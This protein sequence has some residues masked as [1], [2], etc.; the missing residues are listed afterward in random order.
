MKTRAVLAVLIG[1]IMFVA[2]F[3]LS[4]SFGVIEIAE[5]KVSVM[6]T[7]EGIDVL[8]FSPDVKAIITTISDGIKFSLG[9]ASFHHHPNPQT[10]ERAREYS[11]GALGYS[12]CYDIGARKVLIFR[13][14]IWSKLHTTQYHSTISWRLAGIFDPQ[15]DDRNRGRRN[16][17]CRGVGDHDSEISPQ[18]PVSRISCNESC[19]YSGASNERGEQ[20][21]NDNSFKGAPTQ[22]EGFIVLCIVAGLGG[23]VLFEK[24]MNRAGDVMLFSGWILMVAAAVFMAFLIVTHSSDGAVRFLPASTSPLQSR[25]DIAA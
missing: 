2:D 9:K 7:I 21:I 8:N 5:A 6:P 23:F 11:N 13:Q 22:V 1:I 15:R 4:R 14:W 18:L 16:I 17:I 10:I 24:G 3:D 12:G 25:G 19:T 20:R